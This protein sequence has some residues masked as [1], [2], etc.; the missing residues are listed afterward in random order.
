M[1]KAYL[2]I[3]EIKGIEYYATIVNDEIIPLRKIEGALAF[4]DITDAVT[5]IQKAFAA[6]FRGDVW[7]QPVKL[8]KYH[9]INIDNK[10]EIDS[11]IYNALLVA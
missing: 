8:E 4:A 9:S 6:K 10:I 5:Q 7:L 3:I 11:R 1:E 2:I